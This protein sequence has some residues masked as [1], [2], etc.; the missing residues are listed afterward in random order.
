MLTAAIGS[1]VVLGMCA[2]Q[3]CSSGSSS[4]Q[5]G[6]GT[7]TTA[8]NSAAPGSSSAVS[9]APAGGSSS[10]PASTGSSSAPAV[11]ASSPVAARTGVAPAGAPSGTFTA[12]A[13]SA[14]V[15]GWGSYTKI[16]AHLV[17]VQVCAKKVGNVFA[18]GVEAIAYNSDYSKQGEIASVILPETP[19]QQACTQIN[20]FYTAH[21]KVYSFLGSGGTI[22]K[23]SPLKTIY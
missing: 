22:T 19:G 16:S 20:L 1:A 21:L 11:H 12:P 10:S 9:S 7:Q 5:A 17:H 14:A 13:A 18:V 4:T 2:L 15:V 8:G 6:S 23:K 3:G